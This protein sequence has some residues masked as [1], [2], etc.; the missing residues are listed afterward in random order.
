MATRTVL[1]RRELSARLIG[2]DATAVFANDA[3][4][5]TQKTTT[6]TYVTNAGSYGVE[7]YMLT[8]YNPSTVTDLTVKVFEISTA[9]GGDARDSL[10]T[11]LS[12]P[13]AQVTTG[14]TIVSH[15]KVIHGILN[16]EDVKLIISND[17]VLGEADGFTA[18][19]RLREVM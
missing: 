12:I 15:A 13:K 18:S 7:E 14:T 1:Q 8:V 11:T 5:N 10:I 2:S 6:F 19:F 17:T 16:G 9:L 4:V 3:L